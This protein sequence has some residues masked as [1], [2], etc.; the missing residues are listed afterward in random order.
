MVDYSSGNLE[1]FSKLGKTLDDHESLV[2]DKR[3][4]MLM[5]AKAALLTGGGH[6]A[7]VKLRVAGFKLG[8]SAGPDRRLVLVL[9]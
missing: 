2:L 3:E 8:Y 1:T 6:L 5:D 9:W 7:T 4:L